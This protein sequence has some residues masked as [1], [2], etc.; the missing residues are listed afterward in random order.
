MNVTTIAIP[1]NQWT[2]IQTLIDEGTIGSVVR[3]HGFDES[4][5]GKRPG[6]HYDRDTF[7]LTIDL[8]LTDSQRTM[9]VDS[10][11]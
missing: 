11:H 1:F 4:V 3:L 2:N 10:R 5:A 8:R 9:L 6:Y 7:T